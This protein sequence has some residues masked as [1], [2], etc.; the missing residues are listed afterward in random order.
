MKTTKVRDVGGSK[1]IILPKKLITN[2]GWNDDT[3]LVLIP[4]NDGIYM[5]A[6]EFFSEHKTDHDKDDLY[7]RELMKHVLSEDKTI[8]PYIIPAKQDNLEPVIQAEIPVNIQPE[9]PTSIPPK[10]IKELEEEI[11][12]ESTTVEVDEEEPVEYP[13]KDTT[14]PII[15]RKLVRNP[16][17]EVV[18]P[19][20]LFF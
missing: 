14:S 12:K 7:H 10:S 15:Y 5:V 18:I 16:N 8:I 19:K 1:G 9:I 17:V 11:K 4:F 2:K 3:E 6:K 20:D 13:T